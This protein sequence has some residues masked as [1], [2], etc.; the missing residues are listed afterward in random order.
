MSDN[1]TP[2]PTLPSLLAQSSRLDVPLHDLLQKPPVSPTPS[3]TEL[4]YKPHW[5]CPCRPFPIVLNWCVR[6][7]YLTLQLC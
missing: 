7:P 5:L 3:G 6:L 4:E 1:S 2:Q